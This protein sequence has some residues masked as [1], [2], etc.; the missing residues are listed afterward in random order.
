MEYYSVLKLIELALEKL[1]VV[2]RTPC[3][4]LFQIPY[5]STKAFLIPVSGDPIPYPSSYRGPAQMQFT[6]I[7]T[8]QTFT[9]I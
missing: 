9:H 4:C 8:V 2:K 5:E 3:P 7:H 1:S 6:Y